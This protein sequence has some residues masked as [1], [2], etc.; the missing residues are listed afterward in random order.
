MHL[1][2]WNSSINKRGIR[3]PAKWIRMG[4]SARFDEPAFS[5]H[6]CKEFLANQRE[7]LVYKVHQ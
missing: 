1:P 6:N 7:I 4:E 3:S 5:L 2:A